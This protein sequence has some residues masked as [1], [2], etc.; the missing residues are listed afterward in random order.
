MPRHSLRGSCYAAKT[1]VTKPYLISDVNYESVLK[2]VLIMR[3]NHDNVVALKH[4]FLEKDTVTVFME[5]QECDVYKMLFKYDRRVDERIGNYIT[6]EV[7]YYIVYIYIYLTD[8]IFIFFLGAE[9]FKL[10]A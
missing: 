7:K 5:K 9:R 2:E 8:K 3:S 1:T 6:Y 4:V 10:F